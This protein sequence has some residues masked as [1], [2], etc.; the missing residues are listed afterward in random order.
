MRAREQQG[1]QQGTQQQ[2]NALQGTKQGTQQ[3]E[4][5][6]EQQQLE[7]QYLLHVVPVCRSCAG[8]L[9]CRCEHT[10]SPSQ[11]PVWKWR[12]GK[13]MHEWRWCYP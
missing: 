9:V 12:P 10:P 1:T 2:Q 13:T 6:E 4:Q 11:Q 3:D 7:Q 5:Q 8:V